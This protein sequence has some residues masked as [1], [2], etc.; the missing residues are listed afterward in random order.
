MRIVCAD[1]ESTRRAQQRAA[2]GPSSDG[3]ALMAH[4]LYLDG[5]FDARLWCVTYLMRT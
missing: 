5:S 1:P 3:T 4:Q 2:R